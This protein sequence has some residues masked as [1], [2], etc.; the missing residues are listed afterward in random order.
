MDGPTEGET[1][2]V[3]VGLPIGEVGVGLLALGGKGDA[4][5]EGDASGVGDGLGAG[6]PIG[7]GEGVAAA[8]CEGL[9]EAA[10][11]EGDAL[12]LGETLGFGPTEADALGDMPGEGIGELEGVGVEGKLAAVVFNCAKAVENPI[13]STN[14]SVALSE[15]LPMTSRDSPGAKLNLIVPDGE[16]DVTVR[17]EGFEPETE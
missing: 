15:D 2:E 14:L 16:V 5:W 7:L 8:L 11:C 4:F 10:P 3:G 13:A 6:V 17:V 1:T 12:M 9:G